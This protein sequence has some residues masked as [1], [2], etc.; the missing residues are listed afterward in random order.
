MWKLK[1]LHQAKVSWINFQYL[2]STLSVRSKYTI[3]EITSDEKKKLKQPP[4]ASVKK[5]YEGL[6]DIRKE[7]NS[8]LDQIQCDTLIHVE[9]HISLKRVFQ[10]T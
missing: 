7:E 10:V 6:F 1:Y 9:M 5:K 8:S 4:T 2:K 3:I